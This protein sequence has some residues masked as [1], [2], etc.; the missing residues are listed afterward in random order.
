[1]ASPAHRANLLERRRRE[2]GAGV[3]Y[4]S[5]RRGDGKDSVAAISTVIVGSRKR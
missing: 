4:G 1:M 3:V 2:I 5:P